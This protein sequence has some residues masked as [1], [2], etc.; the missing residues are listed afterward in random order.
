[1]VQVSDLAIDE[2][3]TYRR[4]YLAT[5]PSVRHEEE[6]VMVQGSFRIFIVGIASSLLV[7]VGPADANRRVLHA[8]VEDLLAL[9]VRPVAIGHRGFGQNLGE[10]PARPIENTVRAVRWGF[11]AGLSVVEVDVQRTIEGEI[12]AYHNDFLSDFT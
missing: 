10:D 2:P 3:T 1:M 9:E 8:T 11:R 6:P 5:R 12:V 4:H 7:A